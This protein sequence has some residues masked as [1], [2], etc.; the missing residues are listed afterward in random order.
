MTRIGLMSD[1][2]GYLDPQ[3]KSVFSACDQIWHAGDFGNISV[4]DDLTK[5]N[6]PLKAVH[7]NIDDHE[8]RSCMSDQ[9]T[10]QVEGRKIWMT[11]IGGY[12][13]HY[14]ST[15]KQLLK[16]I[17]PD[18][19]VCG[20]SHI[21][22]IMYDHALGFLHLNPGS[23]GKEGFHKVRTAITFSIEGTAIKEMAVVELGTR[24]SI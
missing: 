23:C 1:T 10:W 2:H 20:H 17:K 6:I 4:F 15:I 22:K 7:G 21:L 11:H 12:P 3:L 14:S 5:W 16:D 24:G 13:G 18:I 9:L 8:T 19:F